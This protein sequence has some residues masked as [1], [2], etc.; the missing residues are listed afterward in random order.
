MSASNIEN[1][2][3]VGTK[4]EVHPETKDEDLRLVFELEFL[5]S[6]PEYKKVDYLNDYW[7]KDTFLGR[8]IKPMTEV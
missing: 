4:A 7:Y 8:I 6:L 5:E 3:K 1:K 2:L